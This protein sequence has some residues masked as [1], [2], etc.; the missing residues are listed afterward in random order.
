MAKGAGRLNLLFVQY[1]AFAEA[2]QRFSD[3]GDETYRDQRHSVDYVTRLSDRFS[4]TVVAICDDIHDTKLRKTL[5]SIGI[6]KSKAFQRNYIGKLMGELSPDLIICRT[7]HKHILKWAVQKGI[8]TLPCFADI[9]SPNKGLKRR[10]GN[11][12][13]SRL[14]ASSVFP[15][16][17]NHSLSASLSLVEYLR[18]E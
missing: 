12:L 6:E 10:I 7:P 3:G 13:L 1:G 9:F 17:S 2:Y 14:L 16:I 15:C 18:C 8:P 4:V 11:L 5:R